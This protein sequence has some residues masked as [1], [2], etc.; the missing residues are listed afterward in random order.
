[1]IQEFF[2]GYPV[3]TAELIALAVALSA[4][5]LGG[6]IASR[7]V[8]VFLG[9]VGTDDVPARASQRSTLRLV[10]MVVFL[11]AAAL[12][13]FPALRLVGMQ[14][15]VGLSPEALG[16]WAA[17]SGLRIG[18]ILLMAWLVTHV[19]GL[20]A[21]LV[22]KY[23]KGRPSQIKQLLLNGVD[24]LGAPGK[25]PFYGFGRINVAKALSQ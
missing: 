3:W 2:R 9:G 17:Q 12:F 15:E 23:G 6:E 24:D 25:D 4:A 1:M 7:L 20:V 13:I 8:R 21:Q 19:T 11:L 14:A 18:L 22:A 16:R 10:R 5:Y